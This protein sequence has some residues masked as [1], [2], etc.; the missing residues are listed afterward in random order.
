MNGKQYKN[1]IDNTMKH[2]DNEIKSDSVKTAIEIF[3]N[4]GIEF[5]DESVEYVKEILS[6][7]NYM[8][9]EHCEVSDLHDYA[10]NGVAVVGIDEDRIVVIAP[11]S[12]DEAEEKYPNILTYSDLTEED[13]ENMTFYAA[14]ASYYTTLRVPKRIAQTKNKDDKDWDASLWGNYADL[15]GSYGCGVACAA[16]AL[17]NI[18]S[19]L[20]PLDIISINLK[21][22]PQNGPFYMCWNYG[23]QKYKE[24]NSTVDF[25]KSCLDRYKRNPEKYAP[26]I[27]SI[28]TSSNPNHYIVVC[29]I[30][31]NGNFYAVDPGPRGKDDY[32]YWSTD[33]FTGQVIQYYS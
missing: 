1:I 9:W 4:R 33:N 15:A 24:S 26:P 22:N 30:L 23:Y 12:D 16:M 3:K 10:N 14:T 13:F 5:P 2:I 21:N 18:G 20:K 27:V 17:S 25:I 19:D 28:K 8:S 29:N 31:S 32:Y 6:S 7:D 11:E